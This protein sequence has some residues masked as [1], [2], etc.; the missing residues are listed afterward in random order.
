VTVC[1]E[2]A[3]TFQIET[4]DFIQATIDRISPLVDVS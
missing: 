4:Q 2:D 3:I 1:P